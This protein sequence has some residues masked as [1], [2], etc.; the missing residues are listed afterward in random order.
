MA[1]W[2]QVTS[3]TLPTLLAA[4]TFLSL[5]GVVCA[6]PSR[7]VLHSVLP[8]TRRRAKTLFAERSKIFVVSE[9][10]SDAM[11]DGKIGFAR[12]NSKYLLATGSGSSATGSYGWGITD[13][14]ALFD[15]LPQELQQDI[16]P[17]R[18]EWKV[19][20]V[21][22]SETADLLRRFE[23]QKW[24]RE[25][26]EKGGASLGGFKVINLLWIQVLVLDISIQFYL[27]GRWDFRPIEA[28]QRD[29]TWKD[30]ASQGK[31]E[32]DMVSKVMDTLFYDETW[33]R[34]ESEVVRSIVKAWRP[35]DTEAEYAHAAHAQQ[36]DVVTLNSDE[37]EDESS[38]SEEESESD[39]E[40]GGNH[41]DHPNGN[42]HEPAD[43][44][45]LTDWASLAPKLQDWPL[46]KHLEQNQNVFPGH[47]SN[48]TKARCRRLA[49]LLE[50]RAIFVISLLFM[51]PDS[52]DIYMTEGEDIE[53][54]I[55]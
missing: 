34:S 46:A 53:M 5:H 22:T 52:S 45:G 20:A 8:W 21:L 15:L 32:G 30:L 40:E 9:N 41:R 35:Q 33:G 43:E 48:I 7:A 27:Y 13:M 6:Y 51:H 47:R 23:P 11:R 18:G 55:A 1:K 19:N 42:T 2:Q 31:I 54:P 37:E 29:V 44:T 10:F 17:T 28:A 25:V 39:E 24:A 4:S 50:L 3:S 49:H 16:I 36:P 12:E 14:K 26:S 38:G